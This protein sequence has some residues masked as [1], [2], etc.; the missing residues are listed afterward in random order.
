MSSVFIVGKGASINYIYNIIKPF[1]EKVYVIEDCS[2]GRDDSTISDSLKSNTDFVSMYDNQN[3]NLYL[4]DHYTQGSYIISFN[5]FLVLS[6]VSCHFFSGRSMNF[7]PS[8]LPHYGGVNPISWGLLNGEEFW[9][10]TWHRIS[11]GVDEG[12]ILFQKT[13]DIKDKNQSALMAECLLGG[14]KAV[15][16]MFNDFKGNMVFKKHG[17]LCLFEIKKPNRYYSFHQVPSE[18]DYLEYRNERVIH[19]VKPVAKYY[20]WK[21]DD[22]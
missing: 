4:L 14:L 2:L 19:D 6:E 10:Y 11:K 22:Y 1:F 20:R 18:K 13:I 9:G 16:S 21:W 15:K 7:H 12:E 17:S 8:P 3:F 5:N